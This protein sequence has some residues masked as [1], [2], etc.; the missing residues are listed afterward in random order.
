MA[1]LHPDHL[2]DLRRSGLSDETIE[3][4]GLYSVRPGDITKLTG[5]KSVQSLLAFPYSP[6]FT[7]YKV[8]PPMKKLRYAQPKDS[9]VHLYI[10]PM[11]REAVH[12]PR[13]TLWMVEGEK[14]ALK[15]CQEDLVCV[16]LGGL[17]NWLQGGKLIDEIA[18]LPLQDRRVVLAPDSD[19]WRRRDLQ[20]AVTRLAQALA[21]R[22]AKLDAC[23]LPDGPGRT[24]TGLDDYLVSHTVQQL[25]ALECRALVGANG[26]KVYPSLDAVGY[27]LHDLQ[28]MDIP[29][30]QWAVED[31]LPEGLAFIAGPPSLGKS[32]LLLQIALAV[33]FNQKLLDMW[34]A[35]PGEVLYIGT[36]ET[37][38]R[39]MARVAQLLADEPTITSWP[40]GFT[41]VHDIQPYGDG[42]IEQVGEWLKSHQ[43][44][45][46]VILDILA[47]VRPPRT[48]HSDWYQEERRMGK[49]LDALA[50]QHH[51]CLLVSMHTN[52]LQLAEDPID[53]VHGGSGL[54]SVAPT[55]T[56]LLPG[57]GLNQA[58]WH[59]R[60]RD[61]PRE[62]HALTM[63]EGVWT[64][65]GDGKVA[66]LTEERQGI[67]RYFRLYPGYHTPQQVAEEL[68]KSRVNINIM[69]R[70]LVGDGLL[71]KVGYG[72]YQLNGESLS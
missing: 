38:R 31:L 66:Q 8:F 36:E 16:A 53:R 72:K 11:V 27:T 45:R 55:K 62:Q 18:A 68:G 26:E 7:R 52:R 70:K 49:A 12:D 69:L 40:D 42:L 63:V 44:A 50:M 35:V 28:R 59:T 34:Q 51:V 71:R 22:G 61:T 13:G 6:T 47:D 21:W 5:V 15:G 20:E 60:G 10:P 37:A 48:L 64:Y 19:V 46:L 24:K 30:I 33:C 4:A 25:C 54:P 43:A 9:G 29:D 32:M 14:K 1:S 65:S 23:V 3:Q 58:I 41:V 39:M 2:A 67:L 57:E 17:W 56:V